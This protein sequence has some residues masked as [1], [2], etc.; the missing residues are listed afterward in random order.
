[1]PSPA[2]IASRTYGWLAKGHLRVL[3]AG[4]AAVGLI[5]SVSIFA[6]GETWPATCPAGQSQPLYRLYSNDSKDHFYTMSKA[7]AENA[8]KDGYYKL[9]GTAGYIFPTQVPGTVPLYRMWNGDIADHFY[10]A[11]LDEYNAVT[12]YTKEGIAGYIFPT[13]VFKSVP[14]YR[15]YNNDVKDHFYT[16]SFDEYNAVTWYAKEGITGYVF[17]GCEADPDAKPA[18]SPSPGSQNRS[19]P[20]PTPVVTPKPGVTAAATPNA[21]VATP[22]SSPVAQNSSQPE[23]EESDGDSL[24][25]MPPEPS[26]EPTASTSD[27]SNPTGPSDGNQ[28]GEGPSGSAETKGAGTLPDTG[29]ATLILVGTIALAAGAYY[30]RRWYL[31][32]KQS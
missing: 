30:G 28:K 10:T 13:Q 7:E 18:T 25:S 29:T 1:M 9:E 15:M 20:T 24:S 23:E 12:W 2:N 5:A 17:E 11:S 26:H 4:L 21:P 19:T 31:H 32:R 3:V 22:K 8:T 27:R 14:L 6:A 16:N